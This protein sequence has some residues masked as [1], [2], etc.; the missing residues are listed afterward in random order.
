MFIIRC[1]FIEIILCNWKLIIMAKR[2]TKKNQPY[3]LASYWAKI[4]SFAPKILNEDDM[5]RDALLSELTDIVDE[6]NASSIP[7]SIGDWFVSPHIEEDKFSVVFSLPDVLQPSEMDKAVTYTS[8]DVEEVPRPKSTIVIDSIAL[9]RFIDAIQNVDS[10]PENLDELSFS[11]KRQLAFMKEVS[12]LPEPY[13]IYLAVLQ[14]LAFC[15][16]IVSVED[17]D[18]NFHESDAGFY[19]SLLWAF[20]EFEVFYLRVQNRSLRADCGI[21][22]HEGDWVEDSRRTRGYV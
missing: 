6:V 4:K 8:F 5:D 11:A 20:K 1:Y 22:W 14:E 10:A 3:T 7:K 16:D 21:I 2:K 12:K 9:Y 15:N 18:G 19:L 13:F 17:R